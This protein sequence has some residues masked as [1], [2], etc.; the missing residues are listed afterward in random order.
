MKKIIFL[1]F[2]F[3]YA[4]TS[5]AQVLDCPV[6]LD[7][8]YVETPASILNSSTQNPNTTD[9]YVF[10][11]KFHIVKNDDGSGVTADYGE[12]EVMNA[13][14]IMNT[15]FNQ[16][17][18][19]FKYKGFDVINSTSFMKVRVANFP[20]TNLTHPT[21]EQLLE[22]SKTGMT[23]P[24]YDYNAMNL[25]IVEGLDYSTISPFNSMVRGAAKMPGI[26]S[27]YGHNYFLSN[28]L[29]HEIA[30]NFKLLHTYHDYG[31]PNCEHVASG[32]TDDYYNSNT[33]GD[34]IED[35]KA[36]F[37]FGGNYVNQATCSF[38]NLTNY[39][40]CNETPYVDVPVKNYMGSMNP[41][42]NL[43]SNYLPG[44]GE[45]TSGQGTAMRN[46]ISE[47]YNHPNNFWGFSNAKNTIESLYQPFESIPFGGNTI[48]SVTNNND[49][50]AEVCRNMLIKHRFQKGFDYVFT[51]VNPS[52]PSSAT[53]INLPEIIYTTYTFGVQIN[54]VNPEIIN[55]VFVD[56]HREPFCQTE[57]FVKGLVVSTKV[58]G[59]MNLTLE[60]LNEIQVKDPELFDKLLSEY[61]HIIN[62]ETSS[63]AVNQI[64]IYKN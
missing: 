60:E 25:F 18:I 35:T 37:L 34:R 3:L 22:F 8:N 49:G 50:T 57:D 31:T 36:S 44:N 59:S 48:R 54:Q 46:F 58:L 23:N 27:V 33:H 43:Q 1:F 7:P 39:L 28:T 17:N 32:P 20:N 5:I 26:D 14:M 42:Q 11:V 13:I 45:F 16:F 24:V 15:N 30:H 10:N 41:C 19:F 2:A 9:Q 29:P 40:D 51:N 64:I 55:D 53:L 6:I 38:Q 21:F 63:G 56:C 47:Y 61:Y 62:K 52:D 4:S 12:N